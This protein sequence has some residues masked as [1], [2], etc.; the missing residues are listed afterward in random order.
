MLYTILI[1]TLAGFL[2]GKLITGGGLGFLMNTILGI[3]GGAVGG[4]PAQDIRDW[5]KSVIAVKKL[6]K[7]KRGKK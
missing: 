7:T 6:I 2:T 4:Y 5:H 1:G 3:V